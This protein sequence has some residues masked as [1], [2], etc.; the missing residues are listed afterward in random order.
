MTL[1]GPSRVNKKRAEKNCG[2]SAAKMRDEDTILYLGGV[3]DGVELSVMNSEVLGP[4][5]LQHGHFEH[6]R[7]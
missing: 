2:R 1:S 3:A 6:S 5:F 4:V 7:N